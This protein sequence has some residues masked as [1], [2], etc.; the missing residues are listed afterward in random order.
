M[1]AILSSL[2]LASALLVSLDP[3]LRAEQKAPRTYS[4][5][6]LSGKKIRLY[7]IYSSNPDCSPR[8]LGTMRILNAP[9]NGTAEIV[10]EKGYASYG[11]EDQ[12][13]ECNK[14][15]RDVVAL[16]YASRA[17]FSGR[18]RLSVEWFGE[19]GDYWISHF[20]ITVK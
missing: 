5:V 3:P 8:P 1:K 18:D 12:R 4:P 14:T 11:K 15:L 9:A 13:Y 6:A 19:Y 17:D 16:Y 10:V 20:N 2:L 7:S